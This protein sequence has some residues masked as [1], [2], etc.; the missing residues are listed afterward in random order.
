[1]GTCFVWSTCFSQDAG[2]PSVFDVSGYLETYYVFDFNKP[3]INVRPGFIYSYNRNNEVNLNLGYLK[4]SY[5]TEN[6]RANL[7]FMAG[8]YSNANLAAEPGVLKNIYE[9][10]AGVKISGKKKLWIDAGIFTSHIG[11]ESAVGKDCWNLTRSI[12]ADN[13]PYYE[14]GAKIS[15]S[16]DNDKWFLS[17]LILN[18]WQRMQRVEGNTLPSFG[19][20]VT[21]KPSESVVLNSSTFIG[22]DKPDTAR[23]MRYFHNFYGIFQLHKKVALTL[24]FDYGLEQKSPATTIVNAWYSPVVIARIRTT[25]KIAFSL[26]GEYYSDPCGV[27]IHTDTAEGFRTT[28]VSA[29]VDYSV[30]GNALWRVELRQFRSNNAL[31]LGEHGK[32]SN[33]TFV[34]TSLAVSF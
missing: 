34:A 20:Q 30:T 3:P 8:T 24:G 10:N 11:F 29:N 12:L 17:A 18:G 33:D 27:I 22:T 9:A 21:F 31:F 25:D 7:A 2:K 6:V 23:Q 15:Y 26:R 5:K 14:A 13:S 1:M 16:S 19:T 4:G 28:G 32:S